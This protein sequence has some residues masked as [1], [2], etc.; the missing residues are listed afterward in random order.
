LPSPEN[1]SLEKFE[2]ISLNLELV[3]NQRATGLVAKVERVGDQ[4]FLL[5][6]DLISVV[7]AATSLP[8]TEARLDV[9]SIPGVNVRYL[10]SSLQ[11]A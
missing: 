8:G 3:I 4:V 9:T 1:F 2:N 11:L 5:R 6:E 10:Q 7:V